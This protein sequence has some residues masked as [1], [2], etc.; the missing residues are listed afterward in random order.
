MSLLKVNNLVTYF[1]IG[2]QMIKAVDGISFNVEKNETLA[3]VGESGSGK[4]VTA[5]SIMG[6][7]NPPGKIMEGEIEF[8]KVNLLKLNEKQMCMVRGNRISM[9][10]QEPMMSLNPAIAVGEQIR[11][12]LI[13]HKAVPKSQAKKRSIE[14]MNFVSI[15]ESQVRY[16]DLPAKFSG[17]MRQRIMIAIAIACTPDLLIADEP[18][19]ALDVTIQSEIMELLRSMKNKLNMS[20]LLITHDLGLVAENADRVIVMYCGK[21]LEEANVKDLFR[22]P[23]HPY[24]I[25]L[26]KCIP[27]IDCTVDKL[28]SIPGCIPHPSQFPVGCR[29]N[30]RCEVVKDICREKMPELIELEDGHKVRCWQW[31]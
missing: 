7:I 25:G 2:N 10:Y 8:N 1:H 14:L 27:K 24:T 6:L 30:D 4:S 3:I 18:T 29:F 23:M 9:I 22:R 13:I 12:A 26:M 15:P 20:M 21:I 5:L 19:T 31:Q 11:E 17:G 16:N 28:Y